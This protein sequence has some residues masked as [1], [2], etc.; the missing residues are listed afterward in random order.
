M[1]ALDGFDA[2]VKHAC[3]RVGAYGRI[4]GVCKGARLTVAKTCDIVLISTEGLVLGRS[5][6]GKVK[7]V[8]EIKD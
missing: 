5:V 8:S 3:F 4:T 2:E 6:E 7:S 1:C